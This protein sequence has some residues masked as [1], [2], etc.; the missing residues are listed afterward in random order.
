MLLQL[1]S[2]NFS[3]VFLVRTL[4]PPSSPSKRARSRSPGSAVG[5][6]GGDGG[7]GGNMSTSLYEPPHELFAIKKTKA[8]LRSRRD[9]ESQLQEIKVY[10]A[11]VVVA[12][13]CRCGWFRIHFSSINSAVLKKFHSRGPNAP[14]D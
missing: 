6:D 10:V 14:Q 9:R 12:G 3:D 5:G 11:V 8:L 1:G 2:G 7:G 4:S 13:C